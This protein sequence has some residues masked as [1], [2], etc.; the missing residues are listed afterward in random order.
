MFEIQKTKNCEGYD[1]IPQ[2][3]HSDGASMLETPFT[4]LFET[5]Y[6]QKIFLNNGR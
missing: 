2:R 5:I 3:I 4:S 6:K 1:Q